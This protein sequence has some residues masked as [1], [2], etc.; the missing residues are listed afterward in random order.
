MGNE[1]TLP[2][3]IKARTAKALRAD[4]IKNNARLKMATINYKVIHDGKHFYAWYNEP[5]WQNKELK[6]N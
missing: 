3:F 5:I 6:G 2:N 1:P 4:M